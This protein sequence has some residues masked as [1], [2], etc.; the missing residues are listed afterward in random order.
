M[1][2]TAAI[3]QS[4]SIASTNPTPNNQPEGLLHV[5]CQKSEKKNEPS[6]GEVRALQGRI[7]ILDRLLVHSGIAKVR[8]FH[9]TGRITQRA[10]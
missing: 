5:G 7:L 6:F 2:S 1:E 4:Q 3:Q 8:V 10:L 9:N